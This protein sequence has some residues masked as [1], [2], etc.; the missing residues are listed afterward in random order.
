MPA[1]YQVSIYCDRTDRPAVTYPDHDVVELVRL[2]VKTLDLPFDALE[3]KVGKDGKYYYCFLLTVEVTYAS[4]STK[5]EL[6]HKGE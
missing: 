4:G 6:V 2:S 1:D 5:Y 3:L